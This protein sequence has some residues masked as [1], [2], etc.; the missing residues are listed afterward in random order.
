VRAKPFAFTNLKKL[1][2][3]A[4]TA[5]VRRGSEIVISSRETAMPGS[6]NTTK[7]A[8]QWPACVAVKVR[9]RRLRVAD[10]TVAA[11]LCQRQAAARQHRAERLD[12]ACEQSQY[13]YKGVKFRAL[14]SGC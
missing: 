13:A 5:W 10:W 4:F 9:E 7:V 3:I 14:D 6:P 12:P 1:G 11:Y 2:A 8:C